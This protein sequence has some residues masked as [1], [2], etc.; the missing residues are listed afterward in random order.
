VHVISLDEIGIHSCLI[1]DIRKETNGCDIDLDQPELALFA[2]RNSNEGNGV[3]GKVDMDLRCIKVSSTWRSWIDG[4]NGRYGIGFDAPNQ[5]IKEVVELETWLGAPMI[6][7]L[8]EK[9]AM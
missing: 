9:E 3:A 4:P 2:G 1:L 6:S 5:T 8:L 7:G